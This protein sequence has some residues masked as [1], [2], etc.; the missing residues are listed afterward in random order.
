MPYSAIEYST[1][2]RQ[3]MFERGLDVEDVEQALHAGEVIEE[4]P[5]T[6]RG[7][8]YLILGWSRERPLHVVASDKPARQ[9]TIVVTLYDPR[10]DPDEWTSDYRNRRR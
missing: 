7:A 8:S 1:H 10:T 2:A 5:D 3:R 4:Y 9:V 6:G